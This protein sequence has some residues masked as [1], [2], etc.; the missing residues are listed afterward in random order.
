MRYVNSMCQ[1]T[2]TE[3]GCIRE[4]LCLFRPRAMEDSKMRLSS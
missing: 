4:L 1:A 3:S 2:L